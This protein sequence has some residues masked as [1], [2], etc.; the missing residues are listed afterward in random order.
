MTAGYVAWLLRV[1]VSSVMVA[2]LPW[3]SRRLGVGIQAGIIGG[4]AGA[5]V[6]RWPSQVEAS[7]AAA[8]G[9]LLVA[10]A[11]RWDRDRS[12]AASSLL[13]G[14][15]WGAA[16]HLSPSLLTVL[17]GCMLFELWWSRDR[18]K[19]A[20][21]LAIVLGVV[22]ACAPWVWRNYAVF[23]DVFFI[24]SNFG[25][26]LRMGDHEGALADVDAMD[27]RDGPALRHPRTSLPD[28]RL[29]QEVGEIEYM[30]RARREALAW[31]AGHPGAFARLTAA[32][33]W[34]F[35]F[36][37]PL[38]PL[39]TAA[40]MLLT[41]LALLGARRAVPALTPPQRAALLIPLATYPLVYYLVVFTPRYGEPLNGILLVLAGAEAWR[42]IAGEAG[43]TAED[44]SSG[45]SA[46]LAR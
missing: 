23:H 35:W 5:L 13:L 40:A 34:C 6:P 7:A 37:S 46:G 20:W 21:S 22:L 10:F 18:R 15:A 24:R 16:F 26:E 36:G 1:A 31:I 38:D 14:V 19:W 29:V 12:S 42:W 27:L 4:L 41:V 9:L 33:A 44:R 39:R 43:R 8:L 2:M 25:L 32:R 11:A 17:V 30:R 3:L 45:A 28:A